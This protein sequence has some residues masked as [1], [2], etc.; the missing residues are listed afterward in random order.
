[1]ISTLLCY[2]ETDGTAEDESLG[3]VYLHTAPIVM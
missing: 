3:H 1:M 2:P